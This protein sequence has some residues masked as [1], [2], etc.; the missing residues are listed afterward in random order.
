MV[1]KRFLLVSAFFSAA[2]FAHPEKMIKISGTRINL[3]SINHS[4]AG[5]IKNRVVSGFKKAGLF[6]S[7]IT[8]IEKDKK[9]MSTFKKDDSGVFGGTFVSSFKDDTKTHTVAF[10]D[11]DRDKNIFTFSFD[12]V[13]YP[14][15]VEA[16]DF[17]GNHYINPTYSMM[18]EGEKVSFKLDG[19][20][21]CY[22]YSVHLISMIFS[23]YIFE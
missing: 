4:F 12:S 16:D 14:I 17:K 9:V 15:L 1:I 2:A 10:L 3:Q 11:L 5:S 8:V 19:G 13:S 23:A 18:H 20:E 7:E 6:E 21:A 22:G